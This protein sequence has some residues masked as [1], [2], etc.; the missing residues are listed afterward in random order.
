MKKVGMCFS[1]ELTGVNPLGHIGTKLPVYMRLLELMEN[2]GWGV[3]V[4]TRR[5][6]K[7]GGV[8]DGAWKFEDGKFSL[9]KDRIELDLVYDRTGGV[10]FP[11]SA[12]KLTVVNEREFKVLCWDKWAA[13]KVI[14]KYMP[15]TFL[16]E[17]ES[18][19]GAVAP[20]IRTYKIVLKP[21]NGL[22][23]LGVFIGS[24]DDALNFNF[25]E[26]YKKYI[27]QEFVDT[28][29]G[30]PGVT[31]GMHDLR[32]A[33]VNGEVVWC[34]IRVP[35]EGM[36]LANA[37][38]GGNL[39]EVDYEKAPESV[40]EIVSKI[41]ELFSKRYG[42]PAYGLDFGIDRD[43]TP[44]IFEINDQIGFPKWEMKNREIFLNALIT[45]FKEKLEQE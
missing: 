12:D 11:I 10:D 18:E 3:Y 34:H 27:A 37:A 20:K 21:F 41:S 16:I 29:G 33:I 44:K 35:K 26:K 43:G 31:C 38:R 5:T 1:K 4:L 15:K 19:I 13:Y 9:I 17:K 40:K 7:G 22:K 32:V 39:T 36:L 25:P 28:S 14:G 23:G 30:I 8:F 24:K 6:Y 45:I 2:K 42:S